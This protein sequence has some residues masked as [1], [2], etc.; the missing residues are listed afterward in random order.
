MRQ[1]NRAG[2]NPDKRHRDVAGS[3]ADGK[4]AGETPALLYFF[5]RPAGGFGAGGL[6]IALKFRDD[7]GIFFGDIGFFA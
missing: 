7:L 1:P 5:D 4:L 2:G 6:K 3:M